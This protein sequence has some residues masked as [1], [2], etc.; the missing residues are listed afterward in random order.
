[1]T[2]HIDKEPTGT[3]RGYERPILTGTDTNELTGNDNKAK[4]T[5]LKRNKSG[6]QEALY[7]ESEGT[8]G[9]G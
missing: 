7:S 2:H 1:M 4:K 5:T 6:T 9:E 8:D 3:K